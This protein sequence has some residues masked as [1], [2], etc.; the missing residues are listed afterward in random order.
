MDHVLV[1]HN[2]EDTLWYCPQ[3]GVDRLQEPQR[4]APAKVEASAAAATAAAS[5]ME[6]P[7]ANDSSL[8]PYVLIS[9]TG[10]DEVKE[11]LARPNCWFLKQI[12]DVGR[13]Q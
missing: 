1:G 4:D 3:T 2:E 6:P 13:R 10:Q 5:T 11:S 7:E 9:H 8:Y 12:L